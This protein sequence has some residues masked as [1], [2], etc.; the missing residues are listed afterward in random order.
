MFTFIFDYFIDTCVNDFNVD[1]LLT[2]RSQA[3]A[4][5]TCNNRD[6]TNH[7]TFKKTSA[8]IALNRIQN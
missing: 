4:G 6:P 8:A 7:L 3:K 1:T 2:H 5:Q